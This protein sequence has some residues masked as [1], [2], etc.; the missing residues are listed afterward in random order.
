MIF[1]LIMLYQAITFFVRDITYN[2]YFNFLYNFLLNF[3][4]IILLIM[5]YYLYLKLEGSESKCL[6][7][8]VRLKVALF[9]LGLKTSLKSLQENY[10]NFSNKSRQEKAEIIIYV[11][12]SALWELFTLGVLL[13]VAF[14]NDTLIECL[15]I[16]SSFLI[17]KNVFG[18]AFHFKSASACFIVSNLTYYALN[19]V[20]LVINISFI[21]PI[22][23]GILLA[24]VTSRFVKQTNKKLYR[25]MS[26]EE[27]NEITQNLTDFEKDLLMDFYCYRMKLVA[28]S[29]KYHYSEKTIYN[30]KRK[31]L[32]KLKEER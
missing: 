14:L 20:T 31:A 24:Y 12:L 28:L 27:F 7:A 15:F 6:E 8:E 13:F 17:T 21:V 23:L 3:D 29:I 19:R 16:V 5:T 22:S 9:S 18:T 10:R 26:K 11:I 32:A 30:F 1:I 2:E 25:G 4:F